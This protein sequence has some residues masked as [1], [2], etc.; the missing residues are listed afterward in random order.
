MLCEN[1][2]FVINQGDPTYRHR[3]RA[4]PA[5]LNN[6]Q[7]D[8][9]RIVPYNP[10][11]SKK[12]NAHIIVEITASVKC[13][14]YIFKYV[15]KGPDRA[16]VNVTNE[17]NEITDFRDARWIGSA[18]AARKIFGFKTHGASPPVQRM[19]IHKSECQ[20]VTFNGKDNLERI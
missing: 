4:I 7:L 16:R 5:N 2:Q 11:L 1:T 9:Q 3:P 6:P 20:E 12:F 8:N 14:G 18:K 19:Q 15:T 10:Y 13:F 17:E